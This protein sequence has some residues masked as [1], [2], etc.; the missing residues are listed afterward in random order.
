M[1]VTEFWREYL[2]FAKLD[3]NTKYYECFYFGWSESMAN[4]LLAL[5]LEGKKRATS[6]CFVTYEKEGSPLPKAGDLSIVTDFAGEPYCVIET[7][8]VT[9]L[10]FCEMTYEICSREGED[11]VLETWRQ[12]HER[13]FTAEGQELGFEFTPDMP[14]IFEDF[15]VVYIKNG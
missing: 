2:H 3:E 13:G 8:A 1:T 10:P 9:I 15:S 6:S 14:V 4:E 5:V 7:T 11:E 12:A